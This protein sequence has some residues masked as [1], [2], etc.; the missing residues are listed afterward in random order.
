MYI[1][2]YTEYRRRRRTALIKSK[3]NKTPQ[4]SLCGHP[5]AMESRV[6]DAALLRVGPIGRETLEKE[7]VLPAY[8]SDKL[9]NQTTDPFA[10]CWAH[11]P[12]CLLLV[13]FETLLVVTGMVDLSGKVLPRCTHES[14]PRQV[15][16]NVWDKELELRCVHTFPAS[17]TGTTNWQE[18]AVRLPCCGETS[19]ARR[20]GPCFEDMCFEILGP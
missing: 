18:L 5:R 10:H 16:F 15:S 20:G 3:Q 9:E 4:P 14:I 8:I 7:Q 17:V 6:L 13:S 12:T 19:W 11:K 1:Y 2:I